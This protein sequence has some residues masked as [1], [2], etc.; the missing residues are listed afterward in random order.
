MTD[1]VVAAP[2]PGSSRWR[3]ATRVL[4][5]SVSA[6]TLYILLPQLVDLWAAAPRLRSI[7][8]EWFAVMFLLEGTSFGCT[9][10]LLRVALPE[11]SWYLA[12][13]SQLAS[14]A[15]SR[16]LPG[17]PATGAV[18]SYRMLS[19]AGIER[20][21]AGTALAATGLI[22]TATLFAL[23]L[24]AAALA[25][26]GAPV[27]RSLLVVA[28]G[29]GLLFLLMFGLGVLLVTTTEPLLVI[30][31]RAERLSSWLQ[32]RFHRG[33]G[34]TEDRL[35][36]ER[37]RVTSALGTRWVQALAA[38]V[39]KWTLDYLALVAALHAVGADAQVSVVLLAYGAAAV[40]SMVPI[41]P[42]GLGFVEAG[43]VG[44]LTL[45]GVSASDALLATLAYRIVSY[46]LPLPAGV[47]AYLAFRHRYGSP[48]PA[49]DI[50]SA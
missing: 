35:V 44:T 5:L 17:G 20:G 36:H 14:N 40:L 47:V 8:W 24:V 9:W 2:R 22:T 10:W 38:S 23:P 16:I 42:G 21:P 15:V 11:V 33:G 29:G 25:L 37:D 13:T 28:W 48:P 49:D 43:L 39:G 27:P 46:W 1:A 32:Q 26:F 7:R 6:A 4:F 50:E 12:A 30:G 31:R 41:T 45:A 19:V 34:L 3:V 18:L